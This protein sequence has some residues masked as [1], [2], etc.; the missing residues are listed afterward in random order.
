MRFDQKFVAEGEFIVVIFP[1]KHAAMIAQ[2]LSIMN[3]EFEKVLYGPIP[4][5]FPDYPPGVIPAGAHIPIPD[6]WW[7]PSWFAE[8]DDRIAGVPAIKIENVFEFTDPHTLVDLWIYIQPVLLR[9]YICFPPDILQGRLI[10]PDV[11]V[12]PMADFGFFRSVINLPVLADA[13]KLKLRYGIITGN[14][15]NLDLRSFVTLEYREYRIKPVPEDIAKQILARKIPAKWISVP[16]FQLDDRVE[17][18]LQEYAKAGY[19]LFP[20]GS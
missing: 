10:R 6:A 13:A 18:T 3:R 4:Y 5:Q 9:N 19:I 7:F 16:Y 8:R 14:T 2:V 20:F 15:T 17:R 12:R 1:V 11:G